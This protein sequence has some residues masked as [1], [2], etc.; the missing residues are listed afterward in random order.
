M[1][2]TINKNWVS[3][4]TCNDLFKRLES[5]ERL[6]LKYLYI[7]GKT[8]IE[9]SKKLNKPQSTVYDKI[10]SIKNKLSKFKKEDQEKVVIL[11]ALKAGKTH[12]EIGELIG[13]HQTTATRKI[14]K[15]V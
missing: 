6:I 3:G 7:D 1:Y 13:K 4:N 5:E 2:K 9:I 11:Q 15:I 8:G 12:E 10:Q 14:Q